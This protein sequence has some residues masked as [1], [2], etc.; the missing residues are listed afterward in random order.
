[1]LPLPLDKYICQAISRACDVLEAFQGTASQLRLKEIAERAGLSPATAFRI[2]YTLEHRGLVTRVG[3]RQYQC[4]IRP[5]KARRHRV[6]FAGQ[7]QAFAFSRAVAEGLAEAASRADIDLLILDNQYS[8]KAALKNAET[9]VRERVELVIEFQ[10]NEQV[11][12]VV[13]SKFIDANIPMIAVEIPHPGAVYYGANNYAAGVMGG[14]FL[15][16]WAKQHW[17]GQVDEVILLELPIAGAVPRS[18]LTGVVAGLRDI[19]P[20]IDDSRVIWLDGKGLLGAS[21]EVIRKHLRHSRARHVLIGS[22]N[23]PSALGALR[24]FEEAGRAE[25]CAVVCQNASIEARNEM[26]RPSSR[27]VGSVA[28]HPERYGE[29]LIPLAMDILR[30][31]PVPPA[32]FVKHQMVTRDNVDR[33]FPNDALTNP[34]EIS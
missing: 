27:L 20:A 19:L 17:L 15:G 2:L 11:A 14:H 21:L 6:G 23:D 25:N 7:S 34:G 3:E 9:F 5:P 8:V 26:R 24:A 30:G 29:G 31:K 33:L 22:I 12:P 1:M 18:R 13:S 10:T 4:N 16:R 32:V 28:Y